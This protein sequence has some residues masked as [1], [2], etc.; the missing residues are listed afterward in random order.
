MAVVVG[1]ANNQL[2]VPEDGARLAERGILYVPDFVANAGGV[3]TGCGEMKGYPAEWA[4]TRVEAI[5]ERVASVLERAEAQGIL[6]NEAA[7]RIAEARI[8][9][10]AGA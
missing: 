6:P 7:E 1:G 2:E 8:A 3:T 9:A 5:R 4:A 10:A